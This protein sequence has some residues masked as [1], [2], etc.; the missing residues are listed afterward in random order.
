MLNKYIILIFSALNIFFTAQ[1]SNAETVKVYVSSSLGKDTNIGSMSSPLRTFAKIPHENAEIYLKRGDVFHEPLHNLKNCTIDAYGEGKKPLICGFKHLKNKGAWEKLDGGV[2]RLDL[3]KPENFAGYNSPEESRKLIFNNIGV[4][5]DASTNTLHGHKVNKMSELKSDWDFFQSEVF[6]SKDVTPET[7]RYIYVKL[8]HSPSQNA[9]LSFIPYQTGL[10]N[11]K[12]CKIRNI[13]IRGF[14]RHG[15]TGLSNC[16]VENVDIDTIGGSVQIG[17]KRWVRL[18]NGIEFWVSDAASGN[19]STIKN[20]TI[21]RTYDCG[22]TIQG[23]GKKLPHPK[24]IKFL[25][26]KFYHCRQAFE[27]FLTSQTPTDYIDCEFSNNIAFE[28]GNNEF[29]SPEPRDMN[30]LSYEKTNKSIKISGNTFYG[31]GI[32]FGVAWSNNISNNT[33]YVFDDTFLASSYQPQK[34]PPIPTGD[35]EAYRK[36]F[37]D[38]TSKIYVIKRGEKEVYDK[39]KFDVEL[40]KKPAHRQSP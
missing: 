9:D 33:C 20:C 26:N 12:N 1:A 30:L 36:R 16:L 35:I 7:F 28:M 15:I 17:Y 25:N 14:G 19:N 23:I 13:A 37:N 32:Y 2:W 40:C 38:Y 39:L 27:H 24:S 31:G 10:Q 29:S 22:A 8:P 5:H 6:S 4:I 3:S 18:G 34:I 11:A 21:S